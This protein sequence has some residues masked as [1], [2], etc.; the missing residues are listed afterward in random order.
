MVDLL[1]ER[2][3]DPALTNDQGKTAADV[4]REHGH[5]EL[6]NRLEAPAAPLEIPD[7]LPGKR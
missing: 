3:A 7:R 5:T 4:A 1:L 2:G 6:A